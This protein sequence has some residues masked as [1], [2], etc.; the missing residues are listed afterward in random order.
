[1]NGHAGDAADEPPI[2]MIVRHAEKP[3]SGKPHGVTFDGNHDH[4]SLTVQGWLRAGA[5]LELLASVSRTPPTELRRP[6]RIYAAA[7]RGGKSRRSIE[8]VAPLAARLGIEVDTR[9]EE[10][11]EAHLAGEIGGLDGAT[12]VA[13]HHETVPEIVE[14]LGEVS[15][16]PP[17][18]WPD[19]RF[20]LVWT[21]T[22]SGDGWTFAQVPQLFT[23]DDLA[24]PI[25]DVEE[26]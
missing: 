19:D 3:T 21:F 22:R 18:S 6:D 5:L 26:S 16:A 4:H 24:D 15:P 17:K 9:Y 11:D 13:W 12:L 8:T 23:P 1:M 10:G 2:I 20:D 14:H 7:S 25:V